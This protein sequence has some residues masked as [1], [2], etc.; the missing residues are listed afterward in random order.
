MATLAERLT[1]VQTAIDGIID[2]GQEV[3]ING[4]TYKKADLDTLLK[5][6][7]ALER[8]VALGSVSRKSVAEF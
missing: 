6:E 4:R 7:Q 3:S 5:M 8:R 2:G 1:A